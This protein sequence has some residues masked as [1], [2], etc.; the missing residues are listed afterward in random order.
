VCGRPG[1]RITTLCTQVFKSK[2]ENWLCVICN[3]EISSVKAGKAHFDGEKHSKKL[4][5]VSCRRAVRAHI[6]C[7]VDG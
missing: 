3:V 4:K 2:P 1:V 6:H 7:T 5:A